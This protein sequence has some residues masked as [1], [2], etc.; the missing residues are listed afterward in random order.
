MS[1]CY[2]RVVL[3]A[4]IALPAGAVGA[5]EPAESAPPSVLLVTLDTTRADHLGC[6]GAAFAATPNL[7]A[8][9]CVTLNFAT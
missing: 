3:A 1:R 5:A 7:D 9:L 4:L 2:S 6:Y 8:H